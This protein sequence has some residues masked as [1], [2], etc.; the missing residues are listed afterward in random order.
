MHRVAHEMEQEMLI[1]DKGLRPY[2]GRWALTYPSLSM[3]DMGR[4][5]QWVQKGDFSRLLPECPAH[6]HVT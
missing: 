5:S 1:G 6:G 2:G 3:K 4:V